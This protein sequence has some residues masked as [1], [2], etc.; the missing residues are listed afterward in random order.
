VAIML[1][2]WQILVYVENNDISRVEYEKFHSDEAD[3]YPSISLCFG[4]VLLEERLND[5]GVN[6]SYY[7]N[8][9]KGLVWGCPRVPGGFFAL[10][11]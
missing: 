6:K 5:Y 10:C 3:T 2:V 11:L 4:N 8:F 1:V 7:L 9:L